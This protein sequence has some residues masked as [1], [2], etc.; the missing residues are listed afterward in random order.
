MEFNLKLDSPVFAGPIPTSRCSREHRLSLARAER[1]GAL[2]HVRPAALAPTSS[3][4]ERADPPAHR[5]RRDPPR[6]DQAH[7]DDPPAPAGRFGLRWIAATACG[8]RRTR[9][10][11]RPWNKLPFDVSFLQRRRPAGRASRAA[12][13]AGRSPGLPGRHRRAVLGHQRRRLLALQRA[14]EQVA[15]QAKRLA[16]LGYN[17]VR[18]HH[19]DSDWVD[20]NVFAPGATTQ[21]LNAATLDR[22]D[23]WVKC[24]RDE[25][26][27]R[28]AG[29][30]GRPPL[31]ARR[32][33]PRLRRADQV[34]EG[35]TGL[36]LREPAPLRAAAAL[37][38]AVPEPNQP[39]HEAAPIWTTRR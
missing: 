1:A 14:K 11:T 3:R 27:Y 5:H 7:H 2:R 9:R 16:A 15:L 4:D 8:W 22:I 39:L 30:Q 6:D 19:H 38:R 24:L 25:G 32:R 37:L 12:A 18:I 33:H 20:P 21:Q 35:R 31:P 13:R 26:I 10:R 36:R 23:W 34:G 28:L 17:L 29:P